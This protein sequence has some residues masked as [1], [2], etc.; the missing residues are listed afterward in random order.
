MIKLFQK[1]AN[2][3]VSNISDKNIYFI[4]KKFEDA[5]PQLIENEGNFDFVFFDGNHSEK[6]T[7]GYFE[8]CLT[9]INDRSIFVFD[10]IH[11]SKGMENAWNYIQT[12]PKTKVCI[13]LFQ[14]GII[15]FRNELTKQNYT[16]RF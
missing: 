3:H 13:D 6:A 2:D 1:I 10:D 8:Q 14:F 12:H 9:N 11:W 7:I 4:N 15:F 5:L 16:I